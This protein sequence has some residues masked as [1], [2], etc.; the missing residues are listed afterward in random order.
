MAIGAAFLSGLIAGCGSEEASGLCTPSEVER[1]TSGGVNHACIHTQSGPF[2]SVEAVPAESA[3][4]PEL[5][6]THT[7]YT[8][9][10]VPD[11]SGQFSGT[12]RLRPRTTGVYA[13]YL[14][15]TLPVALQDQDPTQAPLCFLQTV[16]GEGCDLIEVAHSF[17]V[18]R[19]QDYRITFGPGAHPSVMLVLEEIA[20][21][22]E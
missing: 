11:D 18:K 5:R 8:I 14:D 19:L 13:I 12:V 16:A 21:T 3:D 2:F 1:V 10:L 20:S 7:A 22:P 9:T 15:R 6:N 17:R 4:V